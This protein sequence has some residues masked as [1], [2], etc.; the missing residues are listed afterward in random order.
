MPR[1]CADL[2]ESMKL[3]GLQM[4]NSC[5]GIEDWGVEAKTVDKNFS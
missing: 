3:L 5:G 4:E 2:R 1:V